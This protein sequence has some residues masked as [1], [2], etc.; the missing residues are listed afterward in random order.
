MNMPTTSAASGVKDELSATT[1]VRIYLEQTAEVYAC[2]TN[3]SVL[4]G[5]ATL[6]RKGIPVGCLNGG[7]GVCKVKVISGKY[8]CGIMSRAHVSSQEEADDTVLACKTFPMSDLV[9]RVVG[10]MSKSVFRYSTGSVLHV[11]NLK[12]M[13][14][15]S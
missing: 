12:E 1:Q 14:W 10:K 9:L 11:D 7:C 5:M 3:D 15:E 8:R 2:R 13:S 6:G 4:H